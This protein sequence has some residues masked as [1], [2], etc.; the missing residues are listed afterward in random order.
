MAKERARAHFRE[1]TDNKDNKDCSVSIV[2]IDKE[3]NTVYAKV[4]GCNITVVCRQ[5]ANPDV[6]DRV[7]DILINSVVR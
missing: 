4:N 5:Q 3:D 1:C 6:Y 2:N 7:K